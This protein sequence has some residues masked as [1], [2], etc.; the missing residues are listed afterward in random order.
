METDEGEVEGEEEVEEGQK[1]ERSTGPESSHAKS[2]RQDFMDLTLLTTVITMHWPGRYQV[3][4]T[5]NE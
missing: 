2:L 3:K 5:A 1:L 4:R